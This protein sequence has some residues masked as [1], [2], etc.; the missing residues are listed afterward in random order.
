[1]ED[2]GKQWHKLGVCDRWRSS[3]SSGRNSVPAVVGVNVPP[4]DSSPAR[5]YL[6]SSCSGSRPPIDDIVLWRPLTVSNK[7]WSLWQQPS[8]QQIISELVTDRSSNLRKT[9][10]ILH[11]FRGMLFVIPPRIIFVAYISQTACHLLD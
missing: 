11:N 3:V 7:S 8:L 5:M 10:T 9:V 2:Y 6:S 4:N 1:M